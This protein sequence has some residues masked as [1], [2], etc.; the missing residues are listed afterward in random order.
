[1][2]RIIQR[3][4]KIP[5]WNPETTYG[6]DPGGTRLEVGGI[7]KRFRPKLEE[8]VEGYIGIGGSP[9]VRSFFRKG[10][11]VEWELMYLLKR[12]ATTS[13]L[14]AMALGDTPDGGGLITPRP[15][16]TANNLRS[17]TIEQGWDSVAN[18]RFYQL[19]GAVVRN[20][21]M[22]LKDH[23]VEMLFNGPAA[24]RTKSATAAGTLA[25]TLPTPRPFDDQAD[26]TWTFTGPSGAIT[27]VDVEQAVWDVQNILKLKGTQ[28]GSASRNIGEPQLVN[29]E[30]TLKLTLWRTSNVFDDLYADND[31]AGSSSELD[32][33]VVLAKNA[34]AEYFRLTLTDCRIIE[35]YTV[36]LKDEDDVIMEEITVK[37]ESY[38]V[39]L[40]A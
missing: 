36:E 17:M 15:H 11:E 40:T 3:E 30:Q 2:A 25:T 29:R 7:G 5:G 19:K 18:D 32:I 39:D 20:M 8:N 28:A 21:R 9:H 14:I 31:P 37:P 33:Q 4:A 22:T 12:D 16:S 6:T 24:D 1:M 34:N 13:S 10:R 23:I 27:G 35:A 26:A 38:V